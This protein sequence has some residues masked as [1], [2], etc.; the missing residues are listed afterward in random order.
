MVRERRPGLPVVVV[1]NKRDLVDG[2][3]QAPDGALAISAERAAEVE[4]ELSPLI[5]RLQ[6]IVGG[7]LSQSD[8]SHV[9]TNQRHRNHLRKALEAV[10]A[11]KTSLDAGASGDTLALELRIALHEIGAITGEIT[12]EDVLDQIFSRFCIGK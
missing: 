6:A 2:A 11:A 12:N 7:E 9:V 10:L 5:Q 8:A 3:A 4:H 1:A